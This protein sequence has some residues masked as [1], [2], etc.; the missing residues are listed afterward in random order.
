M[1]DGIPTRPDLP[2]PDNLPI[3]FPSNRIERTTV[4]DQQ[5]DAA[6][7]PI[8][9]TGAPVLTQTLI[10]VTTGIVAVAA[11]VVGLSLPPISLAIPAVVVGICSTIVAI[12]TVLGISSQGV[13]AAAPPA[14]PPKV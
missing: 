6:L 12:G 4:A 8:S 1:S 10:R 2:I 11:L 13:R 7:A 3:P 5:T 14:V 9:P